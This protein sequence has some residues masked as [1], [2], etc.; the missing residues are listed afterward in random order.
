MKCFVDAQA[1]VDK[2]AVAVCAICGMGLCKDHVREIEVDMAPV[3][4]WAVKSSMAILCD[5]CVKAVQPHR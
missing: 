4:P 2:E 5:R 3:S 1:G